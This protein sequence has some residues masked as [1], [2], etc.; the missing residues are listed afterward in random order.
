MIASKQNEEEGSAEGRVNSIPDFELV[1]GWERD[2][3][4]DTVNENGAGN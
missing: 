2:G 4:A 3:V 1:F